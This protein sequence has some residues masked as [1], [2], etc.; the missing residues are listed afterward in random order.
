MEPLAAAGIAV[1]STVCISVILIGFFLF[2]EEKFEDHVAQQAEQEAA[3]FTRSTSGK[4]SKGKKKPV[5]RKKKHSETEGE[6]S[7]SGHDSTQHVE[8]VKTP[9][10]DPSKDGK[11][12]EDNEKPKSILKEKPKKA[13]KQALAKAEAQAAKERHTHFEDEPPAVVDETVVEGESVEVEAALPDL[14][15]EPPIHPVVEEK[16]LQS[17]EQTVLNTEPQ[18]TKKAKNKNK[19]NKDKSPTSATTGTCIE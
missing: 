14:Q 17:Q 4:A 19:G 6:S 15:A 2:R 13:K 8:V 5:G 10:D 1:A 18:A 9:E 11:T 3:I 7:Q 12:E 16:P